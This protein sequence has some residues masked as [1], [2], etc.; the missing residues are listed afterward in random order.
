MK[1]K[2]TWGTGIFIFIIFFLMASGFTIYF[3]YKQKINLVTPDYYPKE[4]KYQDIINKKKNVKKF[5]K[6]I[7]IKEL[8]NGIS[9]FFPDSL[10][11]DSITGSITFYRPSDFEKDVVIKLNVND[12]LMQF[13][14]TSYL[15]KG[16]Y[17]II[18]EWEHKGMDFFQEQSFYYQ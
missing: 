5:K 6:E 3:A 10:N 18:I 1:I 13:F 12:S 16:K 11:A 7:I 17:N 8:D 4:L 9:L 14:N 2:I 15:L